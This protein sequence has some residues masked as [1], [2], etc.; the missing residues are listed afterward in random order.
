MKLRV[1]ILIAAVAAALLGVVLIALYIGG[2]A[3]QAQSGQQLVRVYVATKRIKKGMSA[4]DLVREDQIRLVKIPRRYVSG[5]AVRSPRTL[6]RR[7]LAAPLEKGQQLT[8]SVLIF[9]RSGLRTPRNKVAV[10]V[11]IDEI[12][13]IRGRIKNG[14]RVIVFTTFKEG[15]DEKPFTRMLLKRVLVLAVERK[16]AGGTPGSPSSKASLTVALEPE[17]A[18]KLVF[19]SEEGQ[20]WVAL[21]PPGARAAPQTSGQSIESLF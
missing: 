13:L 20:I 8:N 15:E 11:P 3:R 5:G 2:L 1:G 19:A 9:P 14:D 17:D 10:S 16:G 21:W 7:F 4:E 12:A 18:E 6:K